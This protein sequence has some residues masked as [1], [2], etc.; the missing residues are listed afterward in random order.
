LQ[1]VGLS[2]GASLRESFAASTPQGAGRER[3]GK[4][5]SAAPLKFA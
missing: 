1:A 4:A 2:G 5:G 3:P